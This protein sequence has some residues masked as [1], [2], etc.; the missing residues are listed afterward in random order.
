MGPIQPP[1]RN[2]GSVLI[3]DPKQWA[4]SSHKPETMGRLEPWFRDNG[5]YECATI[6]QL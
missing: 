6:T 3:Q 1:V 4:H 5:L 2:S